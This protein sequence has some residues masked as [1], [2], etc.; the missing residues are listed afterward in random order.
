MKRSLFAVVLVLSIPVATVQGSPTLA[1]M[2]VPAQLELGKAMI[3]IGAE[4][5]VTIEGN[6]ATPR[7]QRGVQRMLRRLSDRSAL[8]FDT[9]EFGDLGLWKEVP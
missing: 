1:L 7:L 6:G 9:F 8:F 2:P 3:E 5:S 4:F